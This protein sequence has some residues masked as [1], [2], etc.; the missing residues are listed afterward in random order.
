VKK[1]NR[2]LE[3]VMPMGINHF[4]SPKLTQ[5]LGL[6]KKED[7]GEFDSEIRMGYGYDIQTW[8]TEL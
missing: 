5:Y 6:L 4:K 8:F 1:R 7:Y 2:A 3:I